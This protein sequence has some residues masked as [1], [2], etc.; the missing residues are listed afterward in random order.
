[1]QN[2]G[3]LKITSIQGPKIINITI[4][5]FNIIAV[6]TCTYTPTITSK[7]PSK[8]TSPIVDE[9]MKTQ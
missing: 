2:I 7:S 1:M 8:S 4:S 6:Q 5:I 3:S 9:E